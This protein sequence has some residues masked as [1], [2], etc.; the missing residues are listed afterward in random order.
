MSLQPVVA[1]VRRH[2]GAS[3]K[4]G[5]GEGLRGGVGLAGVKRGTGYL[6][7]DEI[8]GAAAHL[9]AVSLS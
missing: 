2:L 1:A 8:N 3:V 7:K 6:C 9:T 5:E 4:G